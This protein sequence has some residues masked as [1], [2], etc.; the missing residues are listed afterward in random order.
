MNSK[1]M[2]RRNFFRSALSKSGKTVVKAVDASVTRQ[3]TRWIRP[4]FALNELA[5]ILACTRCRDCIEACPH[6]VIFSLPAKLGAKFVGTPALNLLNKGC[7]LCEDWPCVNACKADALCFPHPVEELTDDAE[8]DT[9][10]ITTDNT[11]DSPRLMPELARAIINKQN[12]LPYNGP[13]CGACFNSC[14]IPDAFIIDSYKPVINQLQ[15]NGCGMCRESCI[16]EPKAI[17][18]SSL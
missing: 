10:N 1:S 17:L 14:P 11:Q 8:A 12:C 7:H 5:F 13:E 6:Q 4:P 3:A 16:A 15:C 9:T 2:D 18:I